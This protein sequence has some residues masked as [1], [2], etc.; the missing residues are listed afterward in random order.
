MRDRIV[1]YICLTLLLI[2]VM[3]VLSFNTGFGY[4]YIQ[5]LGWQIQSNLLVLLI[6]VVCF[7][8]IFSALW[9]LLRKVF[10]RRLQKHVMPKSFQELHP[11]ERIGIVWL[12]HAEQVEQDRVVSTYQNSEWLYPLISARLLID[13][14]HGEEAKQWLKENQNPLF[15]L[16]ELLKIDIAL[17][18]KNYAEALDRLEFL[19]VQPLSIWLRPVEKAYQAELR[20][21]WLLLS[22]TCP[23]WI[24]KASH[25][26]QFNP[27]QNLIWLQALL[28]QSFEASDEDQQLFLEWYQTIALDLPD[29]DIQEQILILKLLSQFELF[30]AESANFA[31]GILQ[32]RFV[33]EVLYI[34]LD[35]AL[36]QQQPIQQLE[37]QLQQ[38]QDI[39]PAQPSLTFA[40]WHIYQRQQNFEQAEQLLNQFP[41]DAYMAYL[42]IQEAIK[43]SDALQEDLKLLLQYSKQDFKFDL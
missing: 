34:W 32:Q 37:Q 9:H 36:N 35:K 38:W 19:T 14:G 11:Y 10:R 3:F 29:M 20:G 8:A 25:Q 5:W 42:R 2:A 6:C 7:I 18:D 4:V 1:S 24:F 28:D 15:E 43:S 26:P 13:Q 17:A 31:Q 21:K 39:Y 27:E 40:Q 16:A 33:P 41:D 23:W 22:K 30:N 12:L